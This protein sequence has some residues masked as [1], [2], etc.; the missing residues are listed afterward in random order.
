[1]ND[2]I[3]KY[4]NLAIYAPVDK[5]KK[6]QINCVDDDVDDGGGYVDM[7]QKEVKKLVDSLNAWLKEEL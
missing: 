2:I 3:Y 5:S 1:M 7:N 4:R 6:I